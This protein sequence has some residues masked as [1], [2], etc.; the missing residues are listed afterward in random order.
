MTIYFSSLKSY[1]KP[2]QVPSSDSESQSLMGILLKAQLPVASSCKGEGICGKC[3]VLVLKGNENLSL[4]TGLETKTKNKNKI[5]D[6]ERL[7]CQAYLTGDI[8]IDT[9]YW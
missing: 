3:R 9:N 1:L 6:S 5:T 8:T 7:A 2:L 4:P